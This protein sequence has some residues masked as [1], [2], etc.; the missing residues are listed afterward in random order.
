[1]VFEA[2]QSRVIFFDRSL[3]MGEFNGVFD[4]LDVDS[5]DMFQ[6]VACGF[7]GKLRIDGGRV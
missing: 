6:Q 4:S 2:S 7:P 1:M 3:E 5:V